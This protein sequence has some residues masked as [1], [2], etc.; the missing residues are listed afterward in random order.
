MVNTTS[1]SCL[2][3]KRVN[4]IAKSSPLL[5][6]ILSLAVV[7][8]WLLVATRTAIASASGKIFYAPC[9]AEYEKGRIKKEVE[10]SG[11]N[12]DGIFMKN[13]VA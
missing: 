4:G 13:S 6:Q 9:L 1:P 3:L 5:P 12:D 11:A 8:L 2:F 7:C 10:A